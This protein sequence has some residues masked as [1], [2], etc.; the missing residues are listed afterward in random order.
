MLFILTFEEKI[1]QRQIRLAD[2]KYLICSGRKLKDS[3]FEIL[4]IP[5]K[6]ANGIAEEK[7]DQE[8]FYALLYRVD[9]ELFSSA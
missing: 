5:A 7:K 6:N 4:P 2:A 9:P 3:D 1:A 8:T